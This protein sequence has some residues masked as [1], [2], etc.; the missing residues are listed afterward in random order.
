MKDVMP[1]SIHPFRR[2]RLSVLVQASLASLFALSPALAA[3]LTVT[4]T[5][6]AGAGSLRAQVA[7]AVSGDTIVFDCGGALTCPAVITLSSQGNNQGFPG[8]TAL[9]ISGKSITIAAPVAGDVTL[10][11]APGTTSATSLRLFFIDTGAALTLQNLTL[12]G[13]HAIGG[14][15]GIGSDVGGGGAGLGGAIFSQGTLGLSGVSFSGNAASGGNG[16][17]GS[18]SKASGGGGGMGGDGAS[19]YQSGGGGTGGNGFTGNAPPGAGGSG[20]AGFGGL[21]GGS[22][23]T[24]GGAGGVGSNG[25]GG[26]GGYGG[27]NASDGGGGGGGGRNTGGVGG[28]GGGGGGGGYIISYGI[29][30]VGGFGGGGGGSGGAG[31][32]FGIHGGVGGGLSGGYGFGGGGGGAGFGGAVFARSGTVTVQN[33]GTSGSI[34]AN[35]AAAG[36]G[37]AGGFGG[38]AFGTGLFLMSGVTT[39]FDVAGT[40]TV[41]D[42]ISDD[43]PTSVTGGAFTS[44]TGAGVA[45]AKQGAGALILSGVNTY[46]GGTTITAGTLQV[47]GRIGAATINGGTLSGTGTVG[48]IIL[49]S[50]AFIAPGDSPGT[51]HGSSLTWNGGGA[52]NF[53]LGATNS[54]A[55]SDSLALTGTLTKGN[56]G[57]FVF[58]FSDG[59]GAPVL[60]TIYTLITFSGA[61]NFTAADFSYDYTG[62]D[63][64]LVGT[65]VVSANS[66]QF[67]ATTTPVRL[68]SFTVD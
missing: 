55:D 13:G 32:R 37:G 26:G 52:F 51:L 46:A 17:S 66:I 4:N 65:F 9:S 16:T 8:P 47:D 64:S 33:P 11:A 58:H 3:T 57:A 49:N 34:N 63:P 43:S 56:A 62:A 29:G 53:Q 2:N 15:G 38:A 44:G 28:F 5:N 60:N 40:Y 61:T 14:N 18:T 42:T 50:G 36:A 6:D 45:I 20:G 31:K 21:G 10:N 39:L 48:N 59:N 19:G 67:T 30:G 22:G 7:A 68:Q 24:G 35:T 1:R 12:S 25:G 23:G 41:A 27:G 54:A